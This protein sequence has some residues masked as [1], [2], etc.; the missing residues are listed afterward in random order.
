MLTEEEFAK[1]AAIAF[2]EELSSLGINLPQEQAEGIFKEAGIGG[3]LIQ[4]L[5]KGFGAIKNFGQKAT[6]FV[7]NEVGHL[8]TAVG[9]RMASPLGVST[10]SKFMPSDQANTVRSGL[11]GLVDYAKGAIQRAAPN[12]FSKLQGLQKKVQTGLPAVQASSKATGAAAGIV[13]SNFGNQLSQG[14]Q[15]YL[16]THHPVMSGMVGTGVSSAIQGA[17][18]LGGKVL[19]AVQRFRPQQPMQM[20]AA[21]AHTAMN[22]AFFDELG[23]IGGG[24][25]VT[26]FELAKNAAISDEQAEKALNRYENLSKNNLSGSQVARYAVVGGAAGPVSAALGN[27]I[28]GGRPPGLS[29]L[30]HLADAKAPGKANALRALAANTIKG[31]VTAGAVP[32]IRHHLDRKAE[33]NTVKQYAKEKGLLPK[34]PIAIE[35]DSAMTGATPAKPWSASESVDLALK[36]AAGAPTRGGFLMASEVP[37]WRQP[38]LQKAIQHQPQVIQEKLSAATTPA[39]RLAQSKRVG[40]PSLSVKTPPGPSIADQSV[41]MGSRMPGANK[42]TIGKRPMPKFT[43]EGGMQVGG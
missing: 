10:F 42:T 36:T 11:G 19:N 41:T 1:T 22:E 30:S 37:S 35:K 13:Q 40:L 12:A 26:I 32:I 21:M 8:Q 29:L 34:K 6:G 3:N 31:S 24:L 33:L 39:G 2:V 9:N 16:D 27:A 17:T 38:S 15:G 28:K 18:N 4:G 14:V 43:T 25:G 23:H 5:S 7:K 20:K